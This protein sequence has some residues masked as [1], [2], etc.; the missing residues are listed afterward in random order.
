[1]QFEY[2][3]LRISIIQKINILIISV[4]Y[5]C[6]TNNSKR[7]KTFCNY[8]I[9]IISDMAGLNSFTFTYT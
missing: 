5:L 9:E 3:K 4:I 2:F 1:M 8:R 7:F 6:S